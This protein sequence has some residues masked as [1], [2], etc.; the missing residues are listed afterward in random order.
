[1]PGAVPAGEEETR[2]S[3]HCLD[4]SQPV[5]EQLWQEERLLGPR[6]RR[7]GA[8]WLNSCWAR[9]CSCW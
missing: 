6:A 5:V 7:E 4:T 3:Y 9:R 2:W 8:A 1:M